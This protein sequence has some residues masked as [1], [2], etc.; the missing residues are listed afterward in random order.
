MEKKQ[1]YV[2]WTQIVYIKTV[3]IYVDIPKDVET[4]FNASNYELEI[5]LLKGKNKKVIGLMKK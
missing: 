3:N 2:T 4:R 1:N 5:P